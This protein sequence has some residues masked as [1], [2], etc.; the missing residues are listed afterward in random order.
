MKLRVTSKR[1]IKRGKGLEVLCMVTTIAP[2]YAFV[3][4]KPVIKD[5]C[6]RL[7]ACLYLP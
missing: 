2:F 5:L 3:K 6:K 7:F 4:A 1:E